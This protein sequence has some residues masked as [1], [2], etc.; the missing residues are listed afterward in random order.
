MRTPWQTAESG[1][2]FSHQTALFMWAAMAARFG[3]VAANTPE[4]YREPGFVRGLKGTSAIPE[5]QWLFAI[6]NAVGRNN[7]IAG[8][9][10]VANGTRAG[11]PDI[12]LPVVKW[13][14]LD[15]GI[16]M[17]DI[18]VNMG[19]YVELKRPFEPGKRK[20]V[21]SLQQKQW[22]THLTQAGYCVEVCYGWLEARDAILR[23]LGK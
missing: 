18:V 1:T 2:E 4:A 19:L 9:R 14:H 5:L 15:D 12:C 6:N 10:S 21:L 23:Y 7:A 17:R 3:V 13:K 8:A 16:M 11:V 20:G 22:I